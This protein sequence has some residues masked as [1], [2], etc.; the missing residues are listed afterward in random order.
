[1]PALYKSCILGTFLWSKWPQKIWLFP[2]IYDNAFY[3][4]LGS[5]NGLQ[6]GFYSIFVFL[7]TKI[8][9]GAFFGLFRAKMNTIGIQNPKIIVTN[10][11]QQFLAPFDCFCH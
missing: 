3:T 4:L 9:I 1:M 5:Q 10:D 8:Q 6:M 2:N 7:G 11:Y